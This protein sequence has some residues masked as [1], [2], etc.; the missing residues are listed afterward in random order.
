MKVVVNTS[1]LIALERIGCIHVL[2]Q[3]YGYVIRPQSV[4]DELKAGG[5]QTEL[6]ALLSVEW[7]RT[8]EDPKE[9]VL[10]KELGDGETAAIA[11][12]VKLEADLV[13]LD[14]LAARHVAAELDLNVT[15]SLGILLAAWEKGY[16]KDIK[17][18]VEDLKS[19][20]FHLSDALVSSLLNNAGEQ[21]Q[22]P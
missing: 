22:Q 18:A 3:L 14:D 16:L 21:R 11:L 13:I 12:A 10:R 2:H 19:S 6:N 7:I 1:P 8:V 4:L 20:G 5:S 17:A 9:M 15:G